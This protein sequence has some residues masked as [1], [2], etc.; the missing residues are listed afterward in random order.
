[1]PDEQDTLTLTIRLHDP[2]EKEQAHLAAAWHVVKVPRAD[3]KLSAAEFA[4]KYLVP[5][6]ETLAE[7]RN[8]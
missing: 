7:M 4:E 6:L 3:L 1:M 5:S 2:K 8:R